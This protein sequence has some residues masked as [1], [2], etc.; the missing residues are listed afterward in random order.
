MEYSVEI[1][2]AI[3]ERLADGESLR[4]I[5]RD[6]NM[7]SKAM[8]FRWLGAHPEFADQ[9]ARAREA[10]ADTHVDDM[11]DI[12]DDARNDWMERQTD[13]GPAY[14]L[15]GEHIQRSKVRIDTRKWIAAKM[16]PKVYGEKIAVG[17]AE[18][19]PPVATTLDV[20]SLPTDVLRQ[21]L[22]AVHAAPETDAG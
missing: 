6:E 5:C 18:D 12:A 10:Q 8:V 15:N 19:L 17:G 3:C 11:L 13:R 21:V 2:D 20:K 1:A 9:Y 7:P 22:G 4:S 16:K 14:D